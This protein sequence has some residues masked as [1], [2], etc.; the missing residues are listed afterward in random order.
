MN[1]IFTAFFILISTIVFSQ[2]RWER[3]ESPTNSFL[4]RLAVSDTNTIWAAGHNGTIIKSTDQGNNWTSLQTNTNNVII[5][6]HPVSNQLVFALEW[7]FNIPPYGTYLLKTTDGGLN[8]QRRFFP[9]EYELLQSIYFF[10]ENVG[11]IAGSR[12]YITNNGGQSWFQT[13]RDSDLVANLPFLKIEMLNNNLGFACG[14]FIDVAGVI[15]KTTNGGLSWITNGISP[16]EIFDMVVLDSSNILALSGDPEF[17]YHLAFIKSTN[18]GDT[19]S[20]N[21]LPFYA[22]S[23]GIEAQDS[24][25][26]WSAAGYKFMYSSNKGNDWI[27]IP[28]PDSVSLYD[29][30]FLNERIGF[31]CGEN[32]VLLKFINEPNIVENESSHPYEF[33]LYQNYPNPFSISGGQESSFNAGTNI[34]WYIASESWITLKLYN[35]LGEEIDTIVEGYFDKGDH[36]KLY[37]P[38][39]LLPS[40]IYFYQ[41]RT[42][43]FIDTKKMIL[44]R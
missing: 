6:F 10:N 16:D 3:I 41:L 14:G 9:I 25:K 34:R 27:E 43:N 17:I 28:T 30:I 5:N 26:I 31:A 19:W 24:N 44:I 4:R 33:K 11:M 35:S 29:L 40:G 13:Q 39:S 42:K 36:S 32:G 20:Y 18:G 12:T 2:G 38:K 8:W 23:F 1:K 15:W 22:V 37:L 21:E 7:E